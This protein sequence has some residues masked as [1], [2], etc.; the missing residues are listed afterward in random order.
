MGPLINDIAILSGPRV[1]GAPPRV[2]G[3]PL[4]FIAVDPEWEELHPEWEELYPEWEELNSEWEELHSATEQWTQSGRSS[5]QSG[6]SSMLLYREGGD[7][8]LSLCGDGW[9]ILCTLT[10]Q[11]AIGVQPHQLHSPIRLGQVGLLKPASIF[12]NHH[13]L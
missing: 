13:P 8:S 7:P 5:T 10:T 4:C 11:C 3:D 2:G 6:R 1:G 12:L 9:S